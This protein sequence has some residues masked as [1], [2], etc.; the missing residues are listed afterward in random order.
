MISKRV[1]R[2]EGDYVL[3]KLKCIFPVGNKLLQ[4]GIVPP[5]LFISTT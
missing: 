3:E 2:M 5:I 1:R 4:G